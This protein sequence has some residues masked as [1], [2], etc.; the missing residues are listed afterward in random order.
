MTIL[1]DFDF[2][3]FEN[4]IWNLI[5]LPKPCSFEPIDGLN[6]KREKIIL[7]LRNLDRYFY[8]AFVNLIEII[9]PIFIISLSGIK[10]VLWEIRKKNFGK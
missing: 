6:A 7:A 10:I 1:T 2:P 3:F 9:T 8:K 5:L 4:K